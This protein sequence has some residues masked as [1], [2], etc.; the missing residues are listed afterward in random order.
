MLGRPSTE[1]NGADAELVVGVAI[2]DSITCAQE[3]LGGS[4]EV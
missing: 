1:P 4:P 2:I 3:H